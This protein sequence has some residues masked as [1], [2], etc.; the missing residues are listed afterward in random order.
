MRAEVCQPA[1]SN[2][3]LQQNE[4]VSMV[5]GNY[6]R[7]TQ[8]C[9]SLSSSQREHP[10]SQMLTALGHPNK[11]RFLASKVWVITYKD[12]GFG[13]QGQQYN[14]ILLG[15]WIQRVSHP[16]ATSTITGAGSSN[17]LL[18]ATGQPHRTVGE[19]PDLPLSLVLG[20]NCSTSIFF[21]LTLP[22]SPPA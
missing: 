18:A 8:L 9:A 14:P 4:L 15:P 5:C 1:K 19:V 2:H 3:S 21:G 20:F 12:Y 10:R 17:Q 16:A 6:L 7:V 11:G 13:G 22:T